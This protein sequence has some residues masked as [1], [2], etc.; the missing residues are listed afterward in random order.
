MNILNN[1]YIFIANIDFGEPRVVYT[2]GYGIYRSKLDG[3]A[4][5]FLANRTEVHGT[6]KGMLIYCILDLPEPSPFV[7]ID[8][9]TSV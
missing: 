1:K 3:T 5:K 7:S 8:C 9:R 6:V 4:V 2:D